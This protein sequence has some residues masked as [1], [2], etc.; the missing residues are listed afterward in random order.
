MIGSLVEDAVEVAGEVALEQADGVSAGL[1]FGDATGD[2]VLGG[3]VVQS[4]VED[5]GVQGSVEL[6][7]AASAEPLPG[8]LAA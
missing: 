2:V 5:D 6:S 4:P 7:V 1:A 8:R 3:G